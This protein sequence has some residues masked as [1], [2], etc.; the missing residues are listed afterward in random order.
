MNNHPIHA[1]ILTLAMLLAVQVQSDEDVKFQSLYSK[2][3]LTIVLSTHS[4]PTRE[5]L[6]SFG[7]DSCK[8]KSFCVIWYFDDPAK[9]EVGVKQA[10]SGNHFDPIPG[11]IAIYSKNK[12][13]D[14]VICYEPTGIC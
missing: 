13:L 3:A 8:G 5:Q 1:F 14:K 11:L 10:K 12:V 2:A 6:S 9:A 7:K 4:G